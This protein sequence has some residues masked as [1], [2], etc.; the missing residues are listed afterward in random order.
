MIRPA[1]PGEEARLD[2]FLAGHADSSMFLRGNLAAHGLAGGDHP[3]ASDY[4]LAETEAGAVTAVL[5]CNNDGFLMAQAPEAV[6]ALWTAFA[7]VLKGRRVAGM[8]GVD[9]QVSAALAGL[10]LSGARFVLNHS[11]PLYRLELEALEDPGAEIR[12]PTEDDIPL[13]RSWFFEHFL[14]TGFARTKLRASANA[15]DRAPRAVADGRLR[16]LIEGGGPVAMAGMN[17]EVDGIVQ[18]GSVHVPRD[19]RNRGLGRRVTAA[20]LAEQRARGIHRAVLFAN[21]A[22]AARAYEAI[23]FGQVGSYRIALLDAPR[24]VG[25]AA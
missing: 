17:A 13:L 12:A 14:D 7:Q 24:A 1:E 4:W 19:R 23:G 22:A 2:A 15:R 18:L 25:V 11:E 3:H 6:P 9:A 20:L 10:G 21:N 16:L 5:G 8:T